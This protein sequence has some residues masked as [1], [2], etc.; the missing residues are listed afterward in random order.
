C[1]GCRGLQKAVAKRGSRLTE[2]DG[3]G[4]AIHDLREPG[5]F[6]ATGRARRKVL[7]NALGVGT[8]ERAE[9]VGLE[10]IQNVFGHRVRSSARRIFWS[11]M[12]MRPFTVPSGTPMSS[13]SSTCV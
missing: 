5:R 12:R 6:G 13:D 1:L 9:R 7:S 10:L 4:Q 11:P 2:R 3:V 8:A